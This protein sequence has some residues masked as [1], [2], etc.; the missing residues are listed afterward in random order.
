MNT[1]RNTYTPITRR[2]MLQHAAAGFGWMAFAAMNAKLAQASDEYTSPLT[3]KPP[4]FPGRAKRVIF[5]FMQ[6]GPSHLDTFDWKPELMKSGGKTST[7]SYN[8]KGKSGPLLAP[9]FKFAPRAKAGCQS[10][11]CFQNSAAM[12]TIFACSM[13]CTPRTQLTLRRRLPCTRAV[14]ILSGLRWVRGSP[15]DLDQKTR[16]SP[17]L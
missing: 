11:S 1:C 3:P 9:Q 8:D 14:S 7:S 17:D 13:E 2:G 15:T 16:I 5:L 6:G 12:P 4:H 10:A